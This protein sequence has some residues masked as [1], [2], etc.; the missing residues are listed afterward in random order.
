MDKNLFT[1]WDYHQI[2]TEVHM[3]INLYKDK[4]QMRS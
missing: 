3:M 2:N 4:G 1:D